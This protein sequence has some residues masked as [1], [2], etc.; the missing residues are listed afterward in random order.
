[1]DMVRHLTQGQDPDVV[2][3]RFGAEYGEKHQIVTDAVKDQE[4]VPGSLVQMVQ[5]ALMALSDKALRHLPSFSGRQIGRCT[6]I[7]IIREDSK[8]FSRHARQ[9]P[10]TA[11]NGNNWATAHYLISP[12]E[13]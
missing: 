10:K 3:L 8:S 11:S 6:K 12:V 1:M 4:T 9:A 7:G 5:Y 2:F 13:N